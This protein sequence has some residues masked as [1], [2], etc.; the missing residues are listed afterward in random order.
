M[1]GNQIASFYPGAMSEARD[2]SITDV[3]MRAG[4]VDLVLIGADEPEAMFRT[5]R[6]FRSGIPW[7]GPVPAAPRMDADQTRTLVDGAAYLFSNEYEL[8]LIEQGPA[9]TRRRSA[10]ASKLWSPRSAPRRAD[11]P[12]GRAPDDG[13]RCP[14]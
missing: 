14:A 12:G 6:L 1:D 5:R 4:G 9:G 3:A 13:G 10:S 7:P 2:I 8:A 11:H